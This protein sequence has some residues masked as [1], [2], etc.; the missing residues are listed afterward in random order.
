MTSLAFHG[1]GY[2]SFMTVSIP[3]YNSTRLNH[4]QTIER[5]PSDPLF[6]ATLTLRNV[7][8]GSSYRVTRNDTGAELASG[9]DT[10]SDT[11]TIGGI[12]CF[13]N[14]M[15][16]DISVRKGEEAPYYRE[17]LTQAELEKSGT[18]AFIFQIP[19]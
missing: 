19:E 8:M 16:V 14:P 10:A 1:P 17:A 3:E 15:L 13:S 5:L 11:I 12:P 9:Q 18:A 4:T 2:V 7:V 6:Y